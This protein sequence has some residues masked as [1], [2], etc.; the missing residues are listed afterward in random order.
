M[1]SLRLFYE[2]TSVGL[3]KETG[4]Y[5]CPHRRAPSYNGKGAT[6]LD[7]GCTGHVP[8]FGQRGQNRWRE[9]ITP[10]TK[11]LIRAL[12]HREWRRPF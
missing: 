12:I 8:A 9:A 1:D 6:P 3:Y 2:E 10:H 11:A 5:R 7:T 4:R